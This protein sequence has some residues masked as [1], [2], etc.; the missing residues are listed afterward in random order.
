MKQ[1]LQTVFLNNASNYKKSSAVSDHVDADSGDV[2]GNKWYQKDDGKASYEYA[3]VVCYR[4]QR[5]PVEEIGTIRFIVKTKDSFKEITLS[6]VLY[7][8]KLKRNLMSGSRL[9]KKG[10]H[11]VSSKEQHGINCE[12]TN[13][14]MPEQNG[15]AER[16]NFFFLT[17]LDG[18][19]TLLK[20][21]GVTQKFWGEA[22]LC[23]TY[24]WNRIFCKDCN[25]TPFEKYSGKKL[26]VSHLKPFGC[27]AYVGKP[28][29]IKKK[30]DMRTKIGNMMGYAMHTKDYWLWLIDENKLI[31]TINIRFNE[32]TKAI[33]ESQNNNCTILNYSDDED[34]FDKLIDSL[35]ERLISETSLESPSPSRN[36]TSASIY[37]SLISC[38]EIKRIRKIG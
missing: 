28:K 7:N 32:S 10:A 29:Q 4:Q 5:F 27:L 30:L 38:T 34:N 26:S 24:T 31:E 14:Y 1:D 22:L 12:K 20:S 17:A 8:P 35:P 6:D 23:F 37:S 18:V 9:E 11:F 19:K 3:N 36:E 13:S 16:Y 21:S 25:K 15:V 2:S 33:D